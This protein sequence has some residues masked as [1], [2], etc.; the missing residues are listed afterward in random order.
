MLDGTFDLDRAFYRKQATLRND[1]EADREVVTHPG[2]KGDGSE[3]H[4]KEM[5]SGFLPSRYLVSKGFVVDSTG[6]RSEQ[7]DVI[8]HDHVF[9]PLLWESG[10]YLYVPAESV[11]AVFEVKQK[12]SL[13]HI[14][15]AGQK[16]ASVRRRFRTEARFGW[17]QGITKKEALF[18]PLA[19]LLT[20][21]SEWKPAFGDPFYKALGSLAEEEYLDLG[22]A[23]NQGSWDLENHADPRSTQL[24]VP[25]AALISFCMHLLY[26]LQKMGSVGGIDY[27]AYERNAGLTRSSE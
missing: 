25:D 22:C 3:L 10:G 9:S 24:S 6:K 1:L 2:A 11:Y 21:D 12:H 23:L 18:I 7:I 8:I 15:Y 27:K 4:W 16:A 19:G 26:R 14:K 20:V 5:L 13:E 17:I